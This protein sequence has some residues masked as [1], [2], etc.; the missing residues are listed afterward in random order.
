MRVRRR[1][2]KGHGGDEDHGDDEGH[3]ADCNI[4]R[5]ALV[6]KLCNRH[7]DALGNVGLAGTVLHIFHC[8]CRSCLC[9]RLSRW[10]EVRVCRSDCG[11]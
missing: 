11:P 6:G 1:H 4:G 5:D 9:F 10:V 8:D 2:R 3:M 7:L